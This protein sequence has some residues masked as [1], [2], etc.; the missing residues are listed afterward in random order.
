M[1]CPRN[2][3]PT[4]DGKYNYE[5]YNFQK[6]HFKRKHTR[7]VAITPAVTAILVKNGFSVQIEAG[8]GFEAKFRDQE[9]I[10]AGGKIVDNKTAFDSDILLKVR[11]PLNNEVAL[12]RENSTLISFLYPAQNKE[13]IGKLG[14][15]KINAFGKIRTQD[16]HTF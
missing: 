16:V 11:Q 6:I 15:R 2:Y 10:D 12:I 3:G 4:K 13:L 8:A 14:E 9:Y 1:A 5:T 7:S